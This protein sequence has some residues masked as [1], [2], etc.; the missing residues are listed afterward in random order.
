MTA[1]RIEAV[2]SVEAAVER[3]SLLGGPARARVLEAIAEARARWA[4]E[5]TTAR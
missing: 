5:R 4:Q 2:F 1:E 3:R